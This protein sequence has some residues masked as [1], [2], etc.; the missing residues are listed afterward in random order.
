MQ[1]SCQNPADSLIL[2]KG[3]LTAAGVLMSS[4]E[5]TRQGH[6]GEAGRVWIFTQGRGSFHSF[7]VPFSFTL[8]ELPNGSK[9]FGFE[10]SFRASVGNVSSIE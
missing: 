8:G 10:G 6:Y 4:G 1:E 2:I 9:A 5:V 3:L 7:N